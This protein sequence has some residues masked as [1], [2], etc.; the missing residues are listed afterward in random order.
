MSTINE[1]KRHICRAVNAVL[2]TAGRAKFRMT[3]ERNKFQFA[4]VGTAI[5][6][7]TVRRV[8]AVNHLLNVFHD[9]GTGMKS[10][11]NFFI[12]FFKNLLK[13]VHK[14]IMKE[15]KAENNPTPQD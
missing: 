11:F 14:S 1:F 15:A 5:H 8:S 2:I 7:T 3:A 12:V 9:N 6:G 10:I 13:D 4:A